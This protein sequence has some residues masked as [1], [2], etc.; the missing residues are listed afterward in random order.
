M[1][2][3]YHLFLISVLS[4]SCTCRVP[5]RDLTNIRPVTI[6]YILGQRNSSFL[7][8]CSHKQPVR[9]VKEVVRIL[10]YIICVLL[11]DTTRW[12]TLACCSID[13]TT[14]ADVL[15]DPNKSP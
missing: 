2:E 14:A 9:V 12:H 11:E 15:T 10:A 4:L 8:T 1:S 13:V 3:T 5:K 6:L 7:N